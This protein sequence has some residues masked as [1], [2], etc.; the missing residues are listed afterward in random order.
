MTK[1]AVDDKTEGRM[2]KWIIATALMAAILGG[3]TC[4]VIPFLAGHGLHA[5]FDSVGKYL[6]YLSMVT[7]IAF[8]WVGANT[9]YR[10]VLIQANS[11]I[12]ILTTREYCWIKHLQLRPYLTFC[13]VVSF[14]GLLFEKERDPHP[15]ITMT[16]APGI[17]DDAYYITSAIRHIPLHQEGQHRHRLQHPRQIHPLRTTHGKRKSPWPESCRSHLAY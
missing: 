4:S 8:L 14:L 17:G 10:L 15:R 11:K 5:K 1:R 2:R 13:T 9:S 3:S 6:V 7:W 16:P 12:L